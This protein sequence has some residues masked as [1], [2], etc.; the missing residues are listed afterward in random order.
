MLGVFR[1]LERNG[2]E[3]IVTDR[4]RPA[5]KI[6]SLKPPRRSVESIFGDVAGK[7]K[8]REDILAPVPEEWT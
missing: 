8:Y 4:G 5:L 2:G 1:E 3:L 6:S 7:V